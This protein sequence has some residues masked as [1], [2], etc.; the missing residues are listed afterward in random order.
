MRKIQI[1]KTILFLITTLLFA[2]ALC[3]CDKSITAPVATPIEYAYTH[4]VFFECDNFELMKERVEEDGVN[5]N[6]L[7]YDKKSMRKVSPLYLVQQENYK[8]RVAKYLL[9][10]GADPNVAYGKTTLL[11]CAS[12][13]DQ[14]SYADMN[15]CELLIEYGADINA[16][17]DMGKTSLDYAATGLLEKTKFLLK[18]GAMVSKKTM[19]IV[20]KSIESM[21]SDSLYSVPKLIFE[22]AK[23]QKVSY[24]ENPLFEATVL[25][26]T[27]RVIK[28]IKKATATTNRVFPFILRLIANPKR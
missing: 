9:E 11:M 10:Q 14:N 2:L 27:D 16:E 12:G 19:E 5:V 22:A 21:Y 6:G 17:D 20:N 18:N 25:G 15:F 8:P 4:G 26:D 13:A 1:K 23:E 3:G 28:L 7:I 24:K